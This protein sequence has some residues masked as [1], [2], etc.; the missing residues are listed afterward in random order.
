M[1][2]VR[3][4]EGMRVCG[5]E[6]GADKAKIASFVTCGTLFF[7]VCFDSVD[8]PVSCFVR[9][10]AGMRHMVTTRRMVPG[11]KYV[12]HPYSPCVVWFDHNE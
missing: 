8:F 1:K 9:C 11:N 6:R 7:K 4:F 10:S 5:G 12:V 3:G 2:I